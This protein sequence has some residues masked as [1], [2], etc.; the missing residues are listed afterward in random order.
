MSI[1]KVAINGG[2][3]QKLARSLSDYPAISPDGRFFACSHSDGPGSAAQIAIYP[4]DGG[5][6]VASF[7]RAGAATFNNGF[8]WEPNGSSIIYRDYA[9]GL[10]RQPVT[11]GTPEKVQGLPS[12]RS[13]SSIGLAMANDSRH[14]MERSFAMSC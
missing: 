6:P 3:P 1:W 14:L 9:N 12:E 2:T 10:W 11:G 8:H 13:I 7:D 4:I 5:E